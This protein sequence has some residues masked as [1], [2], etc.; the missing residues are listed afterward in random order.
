MQ[1][2]IRNFKFTFE[3]NF[4]GTPPATNQTG[5]WTIISGEGDIK[6]QKSDFTVSELGLDSTD[7]SGQCQMVYVL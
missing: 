5:T 6:M 7:L 3:R 4:P 2:L 1:A